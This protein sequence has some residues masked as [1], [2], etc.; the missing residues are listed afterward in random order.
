MICQ[1]YLPLDLRSQL[2]KKVIKTFSPITGPALSSKEV[3][4]PFTLSFLSPHRGSRMVVFLPLHGIK[5]QVG[6]V[7]NRWLLICFSMLLEEGLQHAASA[8]L[9]VA[10]TVIEE[11]REDRLQQAGLTA[12]QGQTCTN[13]SQSQ[14]G[15]SYLL[16]SEWERERA[17]DE[18]V[19]LELS[20]L[21]EC[22]WKVA[23][24]YYLQKTSYQPLL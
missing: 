24:M 21:W 14:G 15:L 9:F 8:V 20:D 22:V 4:L 6:V 16:D 7:H 12:S 17:R 5:S 1:D 19:F 18:T 2:R 13:I 3:G 11:I 23:Y 10:P